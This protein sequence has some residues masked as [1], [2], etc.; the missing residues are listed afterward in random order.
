LPNRTDTEYIVHDWG[1]VGLSVWVLGAA[2]A[3][4]EVGVLG[5]GVAGVLDPVDAS[6]EDELVVEAGVLGAGDT[7]EGVV[8]VVAAV[9]A[10]D[11]ELDDEALAGLAGFVLSFGTPLANGLRAIRARR[12][13]AGTVELSGTVVLSPADV[14][15]EAVD[16]AGGTGTVGAPPAGVLLSSSTGTAMSPTTSRA[17]TIQSLR[18]TRSLRSELI[19][20]LRS[21]C[22]S[23]SSAPTT[24][25]EMR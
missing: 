19:L 3:I 10:L 7:I 8:A 5:A 16:A 9:L 1:V 25:R 11:A 24:D 21:S 13:F 17:T 12:T 23:R 6:V 15:V 20:D 18:S 14:E 22:R 2:E 4:V